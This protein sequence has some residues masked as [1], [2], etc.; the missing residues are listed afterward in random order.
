M[1]K[2]YQRSAKEA[3]RP[4]LNLL[5]LTT[6]TCKEVAQFAKLRT[7]ALF[8]ARLI[9]SLSTRPA[10]V[11]HAP[12]KIGAELHILEAGNCTITLSEEL[13]AI[14]FLIILSPGELLQ[15]IDDQLNVTASRQSFSL[16]A[17][18]STED[19]F[20]PTQDDHALGTSIDHICERGIRLAIVLTKD[21]TVL[22]EHSVYDRAECVREPRRL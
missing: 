17:C 1:P 15:L 14:Q 3:R 19:I 9:G 18:N 16:F 20:N 22:V 13:G 4:A 12:D 21:R 11:G 8:G 10:L 7:H 6:Q 2:F 5:R